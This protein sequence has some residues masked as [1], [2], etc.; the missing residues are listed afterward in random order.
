MAQANS[1]ITGLARQVLGSA[2]E[3]AG[4]AG[5]GKK[6]M[7]PVVGTPMGEAFRHGKD[8]TRIY[9]LIGGVQ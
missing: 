4:R 3:N 1:E 8:E 7:S 2:G 5:I 9:P 6:G